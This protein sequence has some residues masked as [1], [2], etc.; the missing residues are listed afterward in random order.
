[1]DFKRSPSPIFTRLTVIAL[2]FTTAILIAGAPAAENN[3]SSTL[4]KI[5]QA[6]PDFKVTATDG[7]EFSADTFRGKVI[8]INF[9]ATWC[10]PCLAELPRVEKEIWQK[11]KDRGLVIVVIGREH[12]TAEVAEFQKKM[13]YTFPMAADPKREIYGKFATKYIPRTYVINRD[14]KISYQAHGYAEPEFKTLLAA[15]EQEFSKR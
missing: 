8:L 10:A 14:G 4:T 9:F 11:Y 3:E 13:K 1:M 7:K 12:P 6:V 15:V 2:L 5:G